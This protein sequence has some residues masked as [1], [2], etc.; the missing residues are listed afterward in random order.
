[1]YVKEDMM[2]T[3]RSREEE[4]IGKKRRIKGGNEKWDKEIESGRTWGTFPIM[5]TTNPWMNTNM[6]KKKNGC[7][8]AVSFFGHVCKSM[9]VDAWSSARRTKCGWIER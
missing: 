5:I 9:C 8:L 4:N 3:K 2:G 1:M 7:K 6:M